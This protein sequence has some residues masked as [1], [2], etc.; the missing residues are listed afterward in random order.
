[1]VLES[2]Q[3]IPAATLPMLAA[4]QIDALS[5]VLASPSTIAGIIII[6]FLQRRP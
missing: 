2:I 6:R 1:M 3:V 5:P 4:F